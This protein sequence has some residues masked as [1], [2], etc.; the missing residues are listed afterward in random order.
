[1]TEPTIAAGYPRALLDFAVGKG[2]DRSR[3]LQRSGIASADLANQDERISLT[4]YLE[5]M[6][7]CIELCR[8]PALALHFGASVPLTELSIVGLIGAASQTVGEAR[9][10]INR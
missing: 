10:Q 9:A 3:L 7:T 2:A 8:E 6:R 5:L 4:R 1:M